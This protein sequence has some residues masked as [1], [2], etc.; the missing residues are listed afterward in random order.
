M[1]STQKEKSGRF[2]RE[3]FML[4]SREVVARWLVEQLD[5]IFHYYLDFSNDH[6]DIRDMAQ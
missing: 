5:D 2:S 1:D 3:A 6:I 4:A